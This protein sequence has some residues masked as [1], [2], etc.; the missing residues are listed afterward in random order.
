MAMLV[1][2]AA[3]FTGCKS[4]SEMAGEK[5][6][7]TTLESATG[8][9]VDLDTDDGSVSITT[10][11]GEFNIGSSKVPDNWPSSIPMYSGATVVSSMTSTGSETGKVNGSIGLTTTDTPSQV[12]TW[13]DS[14]LSGWTKDATASYNMSTGGSTITSATYKGTDQQVIVTA[15]L[16]SSTNQNTISLMLT[17]TY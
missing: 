12:I 8:S 7:E 4:L 1:L 6:A 16:D 15:S 10:D 17:D 13:Y 14:H 9:N 3:S 5:I 2:A 11:D